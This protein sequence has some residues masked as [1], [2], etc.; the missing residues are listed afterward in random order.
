M[1]IND[2]Y[3]QIKNTIKIVNAFK[4]DKRGIEIQVIKG[5]R[6]VQTAIYDDNNCCFF[7]LKE[8]NT[9]YSSDLIVDDRNHLFKVI[10]VDDNSKIEIE[11]DGTKQS[12]DVVAVYCERYHIDNSLFEIVNSQKQTVYQVLN[13]HIDSIDG[14]HVGTI[15]S[16]SSSNHM[17]Q[18]I[19]NK[20]ESIKRELDWRF[21]YKEHQK[22][23][24]SVDNAISQ[25]NPNLIDLKAKEKTVKLLGGFLGELIGTFTVCLIEYFKNKQ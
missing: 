15:G 14:S 5:D 4:H 3:N 10:K 8:K 20:W 16:V 18:N 9:I 7:L 11:I 12:V 2:K 17:S 21:D 22:Y 19:V 23:I 6:K 13:V 25:T 1:W 24:S